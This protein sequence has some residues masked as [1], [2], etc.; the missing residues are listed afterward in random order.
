[1]GTIITLLIGMFIGWNLPQPEWA[2]TIQNKVMQ[3]LNSSTRK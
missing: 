2:R 1:M 3:L